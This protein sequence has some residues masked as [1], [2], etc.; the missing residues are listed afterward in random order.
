[1]DPL[2]VIPVGELHKLKDF[3]R[4]QTPERPMVQNWI[5]TRLRWEKNDP[6]KQPFF[7]CCPGGNFNDGLVLFGKT[8]NIY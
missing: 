1:M 5:A 2:H 4:K 8:V 6:G 7:V 3:L